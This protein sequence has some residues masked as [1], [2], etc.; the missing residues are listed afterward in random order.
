MPRSQ[1]AV[2]AEF[3]ENASIGH[4]VELISIIEMVAV[5]LIAGHTQDNAEYP[6]LEAKIEHAALATFGTARGKRQEEA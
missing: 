6:Y 3:C 2:L 1:A 4:E 5:R